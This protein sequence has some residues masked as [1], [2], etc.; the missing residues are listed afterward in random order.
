MSAQVEFDTVSQLFRR[1]CE[2]YRGQERPLLR[3][4]DRGD[5][6]KDLTVGEVE[7][8]VQCLAGFFHE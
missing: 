3:Y 4:K 1:L 8:R 7:R 5:G 6:W 2:M